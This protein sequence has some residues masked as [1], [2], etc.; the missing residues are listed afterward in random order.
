MISPIQ[1][2]VDYKAVA[3]SAKINELINKINELVSAVNDNTGDIAL[4]A[5]QSDVSAIDINVA[6]LTNNLTIE[7]GNRASGDLAVQLSSVA[8]IADE[9]TEADNIIDHTIK[10]SNT[11]GTSLSDIRLGGITRI[12]PLSGKLAPHATV[13][14]ISRQA[15]DKLYWD[16]TNQCLVG[17][18]SSLG[19]NGF[20]NNWGG[21]GNI[22]AADELG[23]TGTLNG[24][25][26]PYKNI[27]F[28]D[29]YNFVCSLDGATLSV[30]TSEPY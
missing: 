15:I 21:D 7:K 13:Q 23:A 25:K 17:C 16:E 30:L 9:T 20:C 4:K 3:T 8:E 11:S 29:G 12:V 6:T 27:I 22:P 5:S 2:L 26:N 14:A 28:S 10:A 19:P 24:R 1:D 18:D